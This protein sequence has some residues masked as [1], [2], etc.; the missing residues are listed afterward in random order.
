MQRSVYRLSV[1]VCLVGALACLLLN[2]P[3]AYGQ[4]KEPI[5][6]GVM[7]D[8]TGP[9]SVWGVPV[10]Q[11]AR[12]YTRLINKQG[13]VHGH[14]IEWVEHEMGY[15]VPNAVEGYERFKAAGVVSFWSWGT[16][17]VYALWERATTDKLPTTTPGFGRADATDG[18]RFP[19]I[20][21]M[22]A[23]WWSQTGGAVKFVM[24]QW[25]KEGKAG[26]PKVAFLYW[27]NPAGREPF[28]IL[29]KLQKQLG[30][31]LK[32]WS[33]PSPG[34]EMSAQILDI[35]R[36]YRADWVITQMWAKAP[37]ISMKEFKRL[38]FPLTRVIGLSGGAAEH[39]MIAAGWDVAEGYYGIQIHGVGADYPVHRD[40]IQMYK[41][42]GKEPPKEMV[43]SS[44]GYNRGILWIAVTIEAARLALEKFGWP[45][46]GEKV[47]K[48][49]E[50]IDGLPGLEG[51]AP[52][53]KVTTK[54]HEGGGLVRVFQ[55]RGGKILPVTDWFHGF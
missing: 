15:K 28:P 25:A 40:I 41:D 42:E 39:D 46:T 27:D 47:Q 23:T 4:S 21:P 32:S 6:I 30:F 54:D 14:P 35:V 7:Y 43:E 49:F 18:E 8:Q 45:L 26:K 17:I 55:T 3:M 51:V 36:R 33:V 44:A 24:D 9:T 50:L 10:A 37:A 19:Y 38:G 1:I 13:G 5:L 52:P 48:G 29:E 31:D 20:F 2:V 16:P 22:M 53:L 12:D 34:L 11:G